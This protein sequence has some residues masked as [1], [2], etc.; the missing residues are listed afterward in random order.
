MRLPLQASVPPQADSAAP[1][2]GVTQSS[3]EPSRCVAAY[4]RRRNNC[5]I[6][7]GRCPVGTVPHAVPPHC[8][9]HCVPLYP[10]GIGGGSS[11]AAAAA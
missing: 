6:V 5:Q 10:N 4:D 3:I 7:G 2:G 9:C 8:N 1:G 11:G